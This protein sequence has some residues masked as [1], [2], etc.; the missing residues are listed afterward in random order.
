MIDVN[1]GSERKGIMS[2]LIPDLTPLLDVMFML[3]IF[4]V[5]TTNTMQQ[6]FD[7]TLPE[8]KEDALK[9]LTEEDTIKITIFA[10]EKMWA[11]NE[12]KFE[13]FEL[14]KKSLIDAYGNSPEKKVVVYGDKN[15]TI[16]RLMSLLTF[17]RSKGIQTAD[18]VME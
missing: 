9:V 14:F 1:S 7:V 10:E 11:I 12:Q 2:D 8:D 16:D 4:L 17:L 15:A 18:I 6:V 13:D 3:I 5:L